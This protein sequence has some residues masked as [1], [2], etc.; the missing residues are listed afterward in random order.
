MKSMTR[1]SNCLLVRVLAVPQLTLD[2]QPP[3]TMPARS[4]DLVMEPIVGV[5][6]G[7]DL[8]QMRNLVVLHVGL[9]VHLP[10]RVVALLVLP[11]KL[12]VSL[13]PSRAHPLLALVL[14][15]CFLSLRSHITQYFY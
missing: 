2:P 5:L 13:S 3:P 11:T 10:H 7:C 12:A 14:H 4:T 15:I 6:G 1:L 9:P 8:L